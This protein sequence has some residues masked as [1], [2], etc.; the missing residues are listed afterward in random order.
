MNYKFVI[1]ERSS[2]IGWGYS[3]VSQGLR[4]PVAVEVRAGVIW[5]LTESRHAVLQGF[6]VES[7]PFV[8]VREDPRTHNGVRSL[9]RVLR[10]LKRLALLIEGVDDTELVLFG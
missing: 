7:A 4:A 1:Y 9:K 8:S 6:A 5:R 2:F 3:S 10:F